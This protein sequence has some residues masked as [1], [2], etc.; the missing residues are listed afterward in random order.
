MNNKKYLSIIR[1]I[2]GTL[3]KTSLWIIFILGLITGAIVLGIAQNRTISNYQNQISSLKSENA[4]QSAEIVNQSVKI[5]DLTFQPTP[6]PQVVYK[7]VYQQVPQTKTQVE[8]H[9]CN[10]D[11]YLCGSDGS[12][13][14]TTSSGQIFC[15]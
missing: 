2:K 8:Y 13:C 7:T 3:A 15:Q 9:L 11:N 14:R 5:I 4:S 10:G 6:T 12:M 1:T